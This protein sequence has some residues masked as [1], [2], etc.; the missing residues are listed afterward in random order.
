[1]ISLKSGPRIFPAHIELN[2][3][4]F[5]WAVVGACIWYGALHFVRII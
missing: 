2:A 5:L 1:M 4:P 3:W